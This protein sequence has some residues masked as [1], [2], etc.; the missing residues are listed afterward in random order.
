[1]K[2]KQNNENI[3]KNLNNQNIH[4]LVENLNNQNINDNLNNQ[5]INNH[6][7]NGKN[8]LSN[9]VINWRIIKGHNWGNDDILY[10]KAIN[11]IENPLIQFKNKSEKQRFKARLKF[12]SV[13]TEN[14]WP[15]EKKILC[16]IDNNIPY[17]ITNTIYTGNIPVIYK[18]IRPSERNNVL[19][20]IVHSVDNHALNSKTIYDKIIRSNILGI[21]RDYINNWIKSANITRK[22]F[23][24]A[25]KPIITSFRPNFP[26]EYWQMDYIDLIKYK[27]KNAGYIGIL[28]I[29]DIFSKFIYLF[30]V[31][32]FN[33]NVLISTLKK[34]FLFGDIPSK[35][36]SDNAKSF[37][38]KEMQKLCSH[39]GIV[40]IFGK[41]H[42]PQT[43]GFVENKNKQIKRSIEIFMNKYKTFKYYDMLDNISFSINNMKH[44]VTNISPMELHRG[45]SLSVNGFFTPQE[46][47]NNDQNAEINAG[48][49]EDQNA[50]QILK[51]SETN[52][53]NLQKKMYDQR[54][55]HVKN[56]LYITANNREEI[57]KDNKNIK[58]G[59][60]VQIA[61]YTKKDNK[62]QAIL[63]RLKLNN[64][65]THIKSPLYYTKKDSNKT[66]YIKDLKHRPKSI[67][68]SVLLEKSKWDF[69]TNKIFEYNIFVVTHVQ[70]SINPNT[71][72]K[73]YILSYI[74][75]NENDYKYEVERMTKL[76][77]IN[78]PNVPVYSQSFY[79]TELLKIEYE[80]VPDV[81]KKSTRPNFH[82]TDLIKLQTTS[83]RKTMKT[84]T[85]NQVINFFQYQ[86][87]ESNDDY[88]E[89]IVSKLNLIQRD[90][91]TSLKQIPFTQRISIYYYFRD[92][93]QSNNVIKLLPEEGYIISFKISRPMLKQPNGSSIDADNFFVYFPRE[94]NKKIWDLELDPQKYMK[95]VVDG[96]YFSQ[97]PDFVT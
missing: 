2:N 79:D 96:W 40:Q 77:S 83:K 1:M 75:P 28:V 45:R 10:E 46:L 30:P 62:I 97:V 38:S 53:L 71:N 74:N 85:F 27:S 92:E 59:D 91:I 80:D 20:K 65:I 23:N 43:Q 54:I 36:G 37:R 86:K 50:N 26:F 48:P 70:Q 39:F 42:S 35:L 84:P 67:Y 69:P 57:L 61:T 93:K 14:S 33:E 47:I 29:I 95:E 64:D 6:N 56:K 7:I 44:S 25:E 90:R 16:I 19:K 41:P 32:S 73:V 4:H 31:N 87:N 12:Y 88:Q 13:M 9:M 52:Y 18:I 21:S 89:R 68:S 63:L 76:E 94:K 60:Y 49:N 51:E 72:R 15:T 3:N 17:Y 78:D 55:E 5:N 8:D 34:M 11:F 58:I 22:V 66:L 24:N 81:F 82:Y